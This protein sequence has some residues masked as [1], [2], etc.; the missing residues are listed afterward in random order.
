ME[1]DLQGRT[2][3]MVSD[4]RAAA[5]RPGA[6]TEVQR[7]EAH[8]QSLATQLRHSA[9][10]ACLT[11][12]QAIQLAQHG[13]KVRH[14]RG[15][16]LVLQGSRTHL[17]YVL[18]SGKAQQLRTSPDGREVI[19]QVLRAGDHF[20]EMSLIDGQPH[21][22]SVRCEEVSD[23]L[24]IHGSAFAG[25]LVH[26]P[27]VATALTQRLAT[28]LRESHRR[29]ATLAHKDVGERLLQQLLE[30]S[31]DEGGQKILRPPIVRRDLAK[32]IGASREMV[33]R[34]MSVF[35]SRGVLQPRA[36]GS[37]RILPPGESSDD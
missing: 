13:R 29:I 6:R 23:V 25:C 14:Q 15:D 18:L 22:N 33:S 3:R 9:L 2:A 19:I 34:T 32:M 21:S 17:L 8:W 24:E 12:D 35:E 27:M 30:L 20:G 36:D 11:E 4:P 31:S 7:L 28:R 26:H 37:W 10:F 1:E 16:M 5:S